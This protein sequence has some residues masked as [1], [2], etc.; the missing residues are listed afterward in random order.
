ML[1]FG[2]NCPG[3]LLKERTQ[4]HPVRWTFIHIKVHLGIPFFQPNGGLELSDEHHILSGASTYEY[5]RLRDLQGNRRTLILQNHDFSTS[6][7]DEIWPNP[8]CE[9]ELAL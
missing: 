7:E 1:L 3:A 4:T 8:R 9:F 5:Y 6:S 2:T